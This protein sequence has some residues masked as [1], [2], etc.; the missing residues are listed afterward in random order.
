MRIETSE[1]HTD[2]KKTCGEEVD[3]LE[4][5][6][7]A[8]NQENSNV[9]AGEQ[10]AGSIGNIAT[11]N[12]NSL[13]SEQEIAIGK[14]G[15]PNGIVISTNVTTVNPSLGSIYDLQF[16]MLQQSLGTGDQSALVMKET[17]GEQPQH[18]IVP[19]VSGTSEQSPMACASRTGKQMHIQLNIPL[20]SPIQVL[21][22]LVTHN[23]TPLEIQAVGDREQSE[24]EG[25]VESIAGNF[26]AAA[27]DADLSPRAGDKSG[28]KTGKQGHNK[29]NPQ[30]K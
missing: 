22:D 16:K 6:K 11:V 8:D 28:K 19:H 12:P 18:A 25:D 2:A 1:A 27:R 10:T 9:L 13:R 3:E 29:E 4:V 7:V 23:V 14:L 24:K 26:K 30:P 20:K 15:D 21:H 5:N 17:N